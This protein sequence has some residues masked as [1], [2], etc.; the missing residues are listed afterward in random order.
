MSTCLPMN[1]SETLSYGS[2]VYLAPETVNEK[3]VFDCKYKDKVD[4]WSI[5]IIAYWIFTGTCP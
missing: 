3:D 5:G 1:K 4:I 2:L